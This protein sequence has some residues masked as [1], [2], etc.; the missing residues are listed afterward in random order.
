MFEIITIYST[1]FLRID[2]ITYKVIVTNI[3]AI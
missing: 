2:R 1:I 3:I